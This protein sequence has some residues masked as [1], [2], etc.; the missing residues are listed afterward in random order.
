MTMTEEPGGLMIAAAAVI[1]AI[2]SAKEW[3]DD[4]GADQERSDVDAIHDA[5]VT[6]EIDVDEME[7]RLDLALDKR[8]QQL[9][10]R[11]ERVNGVGLETSAA[12]AERFDSW[13]DVVDADRDE[14]ED[15]HG[16]GPSTSKAIQEDTN[17]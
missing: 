11:V 5:Y 6:G 2:G 1:Y 7:R 13:R 14:L 4:R 17:G 10:D 15:V 9:R 12:I 16:I 3:W 8:A